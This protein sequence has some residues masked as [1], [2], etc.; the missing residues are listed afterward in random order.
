ML[1]RLDVSGSLTSPEQLRVFTDSSA[2]MALEY[3]NLSKCAIDENSL[4]KIFGSH[5]LKNLEVLGLAEMKSNIKMM[6]KH[7]LNF[8]SKLKAVDRR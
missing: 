3:L 2:L 5:N 7:E 1:Q 4:Q 8:V 6:I